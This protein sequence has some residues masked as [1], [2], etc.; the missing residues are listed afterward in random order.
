MS[1]ETHDPIEYLKLKYMG[2]CKCGN[3]QLVPPEQLKAWSAERDA[4]V[5][6]LD[7]LQS[8]E[9]VY[10]M[11]YDLDG[12]YH[13]N[14]LSARAKLRSAGYRARAALAKAST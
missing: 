12:Y 11:T 9:T 4:L 2:E 3:C 1:A 6:A 14:T 10:R 8:A 13:Q 7:E 5:R